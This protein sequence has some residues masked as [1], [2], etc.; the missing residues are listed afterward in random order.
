[1]DRLREA[2]AGW[3]V[4]RYG[5]NALDPQTQVLPVNGTREA[6]F[7]FGQAVIDPSRAQPAVVCPNPFYQ[8]YEGAAMLAGAEPLFLNQTADE[9]LR[10]RSR[11]AER[12]SSGLARSSCTCARPPTRRAG[13]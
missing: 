1:M 2:I 8:I 5:L 9:R 7:A 4:R 6:L 11:L 10:A 12:R 3:F 13:C